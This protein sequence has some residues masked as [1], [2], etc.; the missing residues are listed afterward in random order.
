VVRCLAFSAGLI[1]GASVEEENEDK[2]EKDE[3]E[4]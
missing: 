2:K 1:A 3:C 4:R